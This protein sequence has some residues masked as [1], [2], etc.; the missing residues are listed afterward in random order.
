[1]ATVAGVPNRPKRLRMAAH[2][3][4]WATWRGTVDQQVQSRCPRVRA[5][6]HRQMLLPPT[7]SAEIG[8]VPVYAGQLDQALHHI[9]RVAQRQ[10]EQASDGQTN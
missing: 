10:I 8:D 2:T 1:M 9:H 3:C 7:D 6:R 4:N 5:D